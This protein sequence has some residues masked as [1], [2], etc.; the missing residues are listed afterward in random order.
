MGIELEHRIVELETRLEFQDQTIA[1]LN[2]ALVRYERG[3]AH[4]QGTVSL[5]V[6]KYRQAQTESNE[7]DFE[8]PE[9]P[10][11]HY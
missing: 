4:L 5:L 3:L 6:E 9:P 11:P 7:P 10:P 8:G 1:N 2:D